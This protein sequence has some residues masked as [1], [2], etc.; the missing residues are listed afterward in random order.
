[1]RR[2]IAR[3][4]NVNSGARFASFVSMMRMP[5]AGPVTPSPLRSYAAAVNEMS[6]AADCARSLAIVGS[7]CLLCEV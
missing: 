5:T 7:M 3:S 4:C 1:V 2:G 6:A